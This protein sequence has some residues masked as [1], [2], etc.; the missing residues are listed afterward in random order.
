MIHQRH[1]VSVALQGFSGV[2]QAVP[3]EWWQRWLSGLCGV[4]KPCQ[5]QT[6]FAAIPPTPKFLAW[7]KPGSWGT[8]ITDNTDPHLELYLQNLH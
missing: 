4:P 7:K 3:S 5:N 2:S 1:Q 8:G 6:P